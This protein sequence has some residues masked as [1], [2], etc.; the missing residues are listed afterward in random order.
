VEQGKQLVKMQWMPLLA[1]LHQG[2][3]YE[4]MVLMW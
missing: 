3:T 1:Q 4:A 2:N